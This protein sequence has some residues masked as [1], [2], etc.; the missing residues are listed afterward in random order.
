MAGGASGESA[1]G[2]AGPS[3]AAGSTKTTPA[4]VP[5]PAPAPVPDPVPAP[6]PAPAP[7]I[8][9]APDAPRV[10]EYYGDSTIWGYRSNA[11]DRVAVPAPAAFAAALKNPA[12]YDVR[13]EG[14]SSTTACDLL[15]GDG[16]HPA[17]PVQIADSP[18][19]HVIVNFAINDEWRHDL[20]TYKDC[21]NGLAQGA[22]QHGKIMIFETPNPTRDSGGVGLDVY[23]RAMKEVAAQRNI[24]VI[25]QYKFLSDYLAGTSPY[26]ICPDGLH[27][28][29]S[30]Y[31][32]KGEYAA[33]VFASLFD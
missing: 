8:P 27:P 22:S 26:T 5:A 32:M 4:P 13:N 2:N 21:L 25:D 24:P 10:I 12:R 3:A 14:V 28:S 17:W 11:G 19:S 7:Q 31:I 18:A 16:R 1:G 30:V 9:V 23:V 6:A 15:N 20:A 29:E 33:S